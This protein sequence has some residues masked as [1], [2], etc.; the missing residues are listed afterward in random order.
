MEQ[1]IQTKQISIDVPINMDELGLTQGLVQEAVAAMLYHMGTLSL[2]QARLL[3]GKSR[4]EFEEDVL[5]KFGY[6]T[7]RN[8]PDN[9]AIEIDFAE[10]S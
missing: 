3:I 6:T 1:T 7:M 8:N 9:P 2:K 4:R 5:P 10:K